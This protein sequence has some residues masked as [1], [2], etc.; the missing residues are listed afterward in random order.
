MNN[1]PNDILDIIYEKK[2]IMEMSYVLD[3]ISEKGLQKCTQGL[4]LIMSFK[5]RPE[6]NEPEDE[7]I[8]WTALNNEGFLP[9]GIFEEVVQN[10][11]TIHN[12][13]ESD[14]YID[15]DYWLDDKDLKNK[16]LNEV[17][18]MF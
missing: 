5:Q 10:M 6:L 4:H 1:L 7:L 11:V 13:S 16:S 17:L 12:H 2:H 18:K 9:E 3:E 8:V 15:S 14:I